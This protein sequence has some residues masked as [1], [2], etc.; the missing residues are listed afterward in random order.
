MSGKPVVCPLLGAQGNFFHIEK[1]HSFYFFILF[2]FFLYL[3][4][5]A[6][7]RAI[8]V[9]GKCSVLSYTGTSALWLM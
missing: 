5:L 4:L 7:S 1:N 6:E 9:L 2:H 8:H 3:S